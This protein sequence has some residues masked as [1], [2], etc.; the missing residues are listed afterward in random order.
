M[1]TTKIWPIKSGHLGKVIDYVS[2]S[3]KT[4]EHNFSERD[5]ADLYNAIHYVE[6]AEKTMS[7]EKHL[8]VSG[9]NCDPSNAKAEWTETK[10][11]FG[12]TGGILAHHAYQSLKPGEVTPELA[13][14]IGV[15]L[16]RNMWG[17]RFE[18]IVATHLNAGTIHNHL[19]VNSVSFEDG[20]KYNGNKENYLK[21]RRLSDRICRDH[22]LSVI[23]HP[24]PSKRLSYPEYMAQKNGKSTRYDTVRA[25]LDL[26]LKYANSEKDFF[27]L[28][29][30]MGYWFS[31]PKKYLYLHHDSFPKGKRL[32]NL[33]EK[34]SEEA[35]HSNYKF[36][37]DVKIMPP[38][39][40]QIPA[41]NYLFEYDDWQTLVVNIVAV[42]QSITVCP[43]QN[44]AMIR[45]MADEIYKFEKRTA[46]QNLMLDHDLYTNADVLRYRG[47]CEDE[48]EELTAARQRFRNALRRAERAGDPDKIR[49]YKGE[50]SLLTDRL[51]LMRKHIRICDSIVKDVPELEQ[52]REQIKNLAERQEH[53]YNRNPRTRGGDYER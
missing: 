10:E 9:V 22:S 29:H 15:E 41:R 53:Y 2:N 32:I 8:F 19:L 20:K 13:H 49:E 47:E 23:E 39:P 3:M 35:I 38:F 14:R 4:D 43:D 37:W 12:K 33:G 30:S 24:G 45:L 17:N 52:K 27:R 36:T 31:R 1:A 50:I 46:Q 28:M 26:C 34:Y 5:L 18:V 25:D 6:D 42:V 48:I 40:Q 44:R 16:A 7:A 21:F 51:I 11:R